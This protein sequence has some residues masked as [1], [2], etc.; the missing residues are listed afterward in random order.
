MRTRIGSAVFA[1]ALAFAGVAV[2]SAPAGA[3]DGHAVTVTPDA[4]LVDGQQVTVAGTGFVETPII[5]DWSV[6]LCSGAILTDGVTLD[7]A[8]TDCDVTTQPFVFTHADASGNL[9]TPFTVRKSFTTSGGAVTCGQGAQSCAI[10]V[11]QLT[12]GGILTGAAT[13]ISFGPP[14]PPTVAEC[15]RDFAHDHQHPLRVRSV[16][17][18]LCVL[19]ALAASH[20]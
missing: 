1:A 8:L 20:H 14:P 15:F 19:R 5:N 2:A 7:H 3:A 4:G 10:L 13:A 16:R 17:L 6:A 9:S 18:L 11:A 12:E